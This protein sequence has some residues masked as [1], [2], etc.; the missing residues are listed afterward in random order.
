MTPVNVKRQRERIVRAPLVVRDR[1]YFFAED[2]I[3]GDPGVVDPNLGI[4]AKV[5]SPME[6]R[7]LGGSLELVYQLWAHITVCCLG[8]PGHATRCRLVFPLVPY[9]LRIIVCAI[10][11]LPL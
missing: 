5:S 9:R 6:V 8:R 1:E 3:V 7:R 2:I 4:M 10:I 11:L